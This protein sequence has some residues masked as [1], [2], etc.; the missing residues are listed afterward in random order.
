MADIQLTRPAAGS[1]QTIQSAPDG[2]YVFTFPADA[3]TLSK[4]GDNLVLTFEDGA[5]IEVQDFY[6]SHNAE[7]MPSFTVDG[8]EVTGADFFAALDDAL[9]PA[10]GPGARA[11]AQALR[12]SPVHRSV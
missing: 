5:A 4:N 1:T 2:R 9:S 8:A 12:G 3:A 6:K 7:K 10:A 11:T